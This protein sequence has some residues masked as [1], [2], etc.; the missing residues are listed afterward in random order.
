MIPDTGTIGLSTSFFPSLVLLSVLLSLWSSRAWR[1]VA[2]LVSI[3][4]CQ[5]LCPMRG[6]D[7]GT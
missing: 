3:V 1:R 2:V 4:L 7:L 5:D 6:L